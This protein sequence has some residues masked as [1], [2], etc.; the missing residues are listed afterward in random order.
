MQTAV[1]VVQH[2]LA[3]PGNSVHSALWLAGRS[4]AWSRAE[5][6]SATDADA[7]E[8]HTTIWAPVISDC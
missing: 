4:A 7:D 6:S 2:S 8:C 1:V 3:Y 5:Q